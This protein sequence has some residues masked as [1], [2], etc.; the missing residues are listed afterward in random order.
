MGINVII[1]NVTPGSHASNGGA[2]TTV[3]IIRQHA[4][5]LLM[6]VERSCGGEKVLLHASYVCL[7]FSSQC[8]V[9][10]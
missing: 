7:G 5:L 2:E 8:L 1:E 9:A 10:Q 6:Q 4:N 3:N